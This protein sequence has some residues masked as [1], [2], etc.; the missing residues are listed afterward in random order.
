ME[1]EPIY[2]E[3]G[4]FLIHPDTL[5]EKVKLEG[6]NSRNTLLRAGTFKLLPNSEWAKYKKEMDDTIGI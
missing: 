2:D 5:P 1:K 6:H 3:S 4:L